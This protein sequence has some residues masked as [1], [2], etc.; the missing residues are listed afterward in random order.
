[1]PDKICMA[2]DAPAVNPNVEAFSQAFTKS[3]DDAFSNND[4]NAGTIATKNVA[5]AF[6]ND[7]KDLL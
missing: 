4:W 1:M 6:L 2:G 7:R 3:L 5:K